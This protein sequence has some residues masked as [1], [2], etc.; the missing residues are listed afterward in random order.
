MKFIKINPANYIQALERAK[1]A[2]TQRSYCATYLA[3]ILLLQAVVALAVEPA[4]AKASSE[5]P[6][7]ASEST[8]TAQNGI[9][10]DRLLRLSLIHIFQHAAAECRGADSTHPGR[11]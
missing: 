8:Q 4:A 11:H 7:P 10:F 9:P 6:A 2:L 3:A 1:K 5:A